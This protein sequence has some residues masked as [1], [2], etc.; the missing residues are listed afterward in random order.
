MLWRRIFKALHEL[1]AV[2]VMGSFAAFLVLVATAPDPAESLAGYA[3]VRNGIA[4]VS[5]WVLV[6]SLLLVLCSGLVTWVVR[7]GG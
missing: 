1:G 5:R 4:A 7:L 2:G 3:A 6:P